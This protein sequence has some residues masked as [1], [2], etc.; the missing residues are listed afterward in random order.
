MSIANFQIF[1]YKKFALVWCKPN[2]NAIKRGVRPQKRSLEHPASVTG[3]SV[4]LTESCE[5]TISW[6]QYGHLKDIAGTIATT[7]SMPLL[8]PVRCA[9]VL[10]GAGFGWNVGAGSIAMQVERV[11]AWPCRSAL[12]APLLLQARAEASVL[13]AFSARRSEP[14]GG[15]DAPWSGAIDDLIT[16]DAASRLAHL[17]CLMPSRPLRPW[18]AVAGGATLARSAPLLALPAKLQR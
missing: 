9:V 12:T 8:P 4:E 13:D 7:T 2:L 3:E 14:F 1:I 6:S 5:A 11:V 17:V 16:K 10:A 15:S 18:I